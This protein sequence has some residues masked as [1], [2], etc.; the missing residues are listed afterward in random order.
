MK[1]SSVRTQVVINV[2]FTV[3]K[4]V[5]LLMS[6]W[7]ADL[8]L[9]AS[10]MGLLLLFRRQG[11]LWGNLLQLGFSQSLQKFYTMNADAVKRQS[12]WGVLNRWVISASVTALITSII[13]SS[14]L[15]ELL[16]GSSIVV[17]ACAFGLYIGGLSLGFMACSSW[18]AEFRFIH[19]NIIDWLNGSLIFIVCVL[20][21]GQTYSE[22]IPVMLA[23]LTLFASCVSLLIFGSRY[24]SNIS[25]F[26]R[27]YKLDKTIVRFG[28]TRG[29]SSFLDMGIL[30]VGPWI[31]RDNSQ[32]AGYL[33]ISYNVLR[34]AQIM[35]MP[36]AQVLALRS[37][38][39]RHN[40]DQE[41]RSVLRLAALSVVG[42]SIAVGAYYLFGESALSLW[43]PN[44]ANEV[45]LILDR[46]IVFVPAFCLFYSLRN[47]IELNYL[48]PCNMVI[49][50][51][52]ILGFIGG[53]YSS[54]VQGLDAA[55][56][57]SQVMLGVF[58]SHHFAH[59]ALFYLN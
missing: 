58:F 32:Q 13:F 29:I 52:A 50:S 28:V 6:I 37:N 21:F 27:S 39:Y 53:Y 38:S 7:I 41:A 10:T 44:S 2:G 31:L 1:D 19:A 36:V 17:L 12:L 25:F 42:A 23:M 59:L 26:E 20:L 22:H 5:S 56:T 11:A 30:V 34:L 54:P 16:F 46:L 15:S 55:I 8:Y 40:H 14:Q 24:A 4:A 51:A 3:I 33:L 9:T 35:I 57:G 18:M 45:A 47:Y 49:L 43:L 48:F